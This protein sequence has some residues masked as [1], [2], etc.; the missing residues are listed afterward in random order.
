MGSLLFEFN[1][2]LIAVRACAYIELQPSLFPV[3]TLIPPV[4]FP[5][6]NRPYVFELLPNGSGLVAII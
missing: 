1:T 2:P 6:C 3:P 5:L 4:L